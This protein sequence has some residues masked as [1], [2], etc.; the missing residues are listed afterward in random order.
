MVGRCIEEAFEGTSK[1]QQH[2]SSRAGKSGGVG[3][4]L[5]RKELKQVGHV[6]DNPR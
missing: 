3:A 1:D 6:C 4:E 2:F 5:R